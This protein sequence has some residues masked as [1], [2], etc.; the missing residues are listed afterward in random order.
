MKKRRSLVATKLLNYSSLKS[1]I[2]PTSRVRHVTDTHVTSQIIHNLKYSND[3]TVIQKRKTLLLPSSSRIHKMMMRLA[4]RLPYVACETN[5]GIQ[6]PTASTPLHRRLKRNRP[7]KPS[8]VSRCF[9][10]NSH[11]TRKTHRRTISSTTRRLHLERESN[12][13]NTTNTRVYETG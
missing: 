6:A 12:R 2:F 5:D 10:K 1:L 7:A 13:W 9:R 8:T 11:R 3:E 4:L